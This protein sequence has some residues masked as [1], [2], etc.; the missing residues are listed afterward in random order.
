MILNKKQTKEFILKVAQESLPSIDRVG[1]D[2]INHAQAV[3]I[4]AIRKAIGA[5]VA[6]NRRGKK[7]LSAPVSAVIPPP[8]RRR[9]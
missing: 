4:E 6:Q 9:A 1:E 8:K 7:T 3:A 5:A 2:M